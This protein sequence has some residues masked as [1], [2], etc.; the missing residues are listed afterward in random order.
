MGWLRLI[1]SFK[2][3]VF[4]AKEPYKRDP[5]LQ[6]GPVILSILQTVATCVVVRCSELQSVEAT[7]ELPYRSVNMLQCVAVCCSALQS[8]AVC[9][10]VA[11]RYSVLQ[12]V[13]A[14]YSVLQCVAVRCSVLQSLTLCC[15]ALQCVAVCCSTLQ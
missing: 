3:Q 12:C 15:S 6:K 5:I 10:S 1:G 7:H 4:F 9:C 11:V 13:T 2:F 14:R 8:V